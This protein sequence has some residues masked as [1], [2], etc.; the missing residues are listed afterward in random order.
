MGAESNWLLERILF[1]K[2]LKAIFD[3]DETQV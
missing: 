3:P 2:T 1:V